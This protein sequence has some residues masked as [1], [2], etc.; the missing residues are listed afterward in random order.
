MSTEVDDT[1][2]RMKAAI[3]KVND[4]LEYTSSKN[5]HF[6][7][8][9]VTKSAHQCFRSLGLVDH[10]SSCCPACNIAR[11]NFLCI[12]YFASAPRTG[13]R[14]SRIRRTVQVS[15]RFGHVLWLFVVLQLNRSAG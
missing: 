9:L 13:V 3:K 6:I 11:S 4:L 14:A 12:K 5:R 7:T 8:R 1:D 15:V 2:N 10:R